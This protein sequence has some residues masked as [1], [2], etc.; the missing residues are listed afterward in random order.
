MNLSATTPT[1]SDVESTSATDG[2]EQLVTFDHR[3]I[4]EPDLDGLLIIFTLD[5]SCLRVDP[6]VNAFSVKCLRNLFANERLMGWK[7]AIEAFQDR[8]F[9]GPETLPSL[10]QFNSDDAAAKNDEAVRYLV[11][12]G[13]FAACPYTGFGQAWY[14]RHRRLR[15]GGDDN[16]LRRTEYALAICGTYGHFKWRCDST[17]ASHEGDTGFVQPG[18]LASVTP[19]FGE[20]VTVS[21]RCS[22][23]DVARDRWID[24]GGTHG[25]GS[26]FAGAKQRL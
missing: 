24:A 16:R 5:V 4:F 8:H 20:R 26:H 9:S 22:D 25:D 2:N 18:N 3:S 6:N 10:S 21:H 14:R 11:G 7:E 23:I 1:E 17:L 12:S 13:C 15:P 19:V